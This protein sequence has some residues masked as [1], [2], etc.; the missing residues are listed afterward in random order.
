MAGRIS[1]DYPKAAITNA[2]VSG[3]RVEDVIQQIQAFE[4]QSFDLVIIQ[5]GGNDVTNFTNLAAVKQNMEI[6]LKKAKT[7]SPHI[8][9]WSSGAVG[10]AP[11]FIPPFSWAF[12]WESHRMYTN[13]SNA[14]NN[15]GATYINLPDIENDY[16]PDNFHVNS[17]AYGLWYEKCRP[18]IQES[19]KS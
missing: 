2:A 9:V 4:K 16:A 18:K 1:N 11:I 10:S 14:V 19:L 7:I 8:L 15:A 5:I 6:I 12:T 17:N 3:A 13:L